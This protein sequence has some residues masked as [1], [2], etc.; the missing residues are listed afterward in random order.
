[1][2]CSINM[3]GR[4]HERFS[5]RHSNNNGGSLVSQ[6]AA[7][8]PSPQTLADADRCL[9]PEGRFGRSCAPTLL[10]WIPDQA[11]VAGPP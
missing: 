3:A 8:C 7:G 4:R 10:M 11:P 2:L 9:T 1:M 5:A 6:D